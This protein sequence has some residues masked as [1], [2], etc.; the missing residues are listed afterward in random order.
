MAR[1]IVQGIAYCLTRELLADGKLIRPRLT[2]S[3]FL[4]Y[5]RWNFVGSYS[6][7]RGLS[8]YKYL[9]PDKVTY[10]CVTRGVEVVHDH[11]HPSYGEQQKDFH[12]APHRKREASDYPIRVK[13][14]RLFRGY[15][16]TFRT[17]RD[18][19]IT[20]SIWNIM[21]H[22]PRQKISGE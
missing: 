3:S 8:T 20:E 2:S 13:V 22:N 4:D 10:F 16:I 18:I 19:E 17:N 7:Y 5:L 9:H 11:E 14:P 6:I 21:G 1:I 12:V 15:P